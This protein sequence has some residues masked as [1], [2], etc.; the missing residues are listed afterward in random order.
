[1]KHL[2]H[3]CIGLSLLVATG[4][5]GIGPSS[6]GVTTLTLSGSSGSAFTGYVMRDGQRVDVSAITPW[7]FTGSGVGKFEFKKSQPEASMQFEA[8]YD[9]PSGAHA[10]QAMAIPSG[11]A[12][13]RGRASHHGFAMELLP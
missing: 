10:N 1:M 8:L 11:T 12:G 2:H 7:T 3:F 4:C 5:A 13:V 6:S 9:E